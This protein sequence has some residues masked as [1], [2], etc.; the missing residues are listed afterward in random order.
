M[1]RGQHLWQGQKLLTYS[2]EDLRDVLRLLVRYHAEATGRLDLTDRAVMALPRRELFHQVERL[3][4]A[5][6]A[7]RPL[8]PR[9]LPASPLPTPTASRSAR[10]A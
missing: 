3:D 8:P 5:L 9:L 10:S 2:D 1:N 6:D 4:R 7:F